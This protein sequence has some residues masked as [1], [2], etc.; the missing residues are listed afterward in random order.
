MELYR[1]LAVEGIA[2][3]TRYAFNLELGCI[4]A[5]D[6]L[7]EATLP[8]WYIWVAEDTPPTVGTAFVSP[9]PVSRVNLLN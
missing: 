6:W 3:I 5:D 2:E 4:F 1:R 7:L 8:P 9:K